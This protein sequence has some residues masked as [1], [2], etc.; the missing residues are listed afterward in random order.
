[1]LGGL[2]CAEKCEPD[3]DMRSY[4]QVRERFVDLNGKTDEQRVSILE[5]NLQE[6]YSDFT[7]FPLGYTRYDLG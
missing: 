2:H 7:A 1:M 5:R 6:S 4:F 3:A